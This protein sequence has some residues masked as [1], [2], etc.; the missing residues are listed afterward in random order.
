MMHCPDNLRFE[1]DLWNQGFGSIAGIDEV[2]RGPL[3]GPVVAA[4]VVFPPKF[5]LT[6]VTDSKKI[7]E[8]QR[9]ILSDLIKKH[10]LNIR[11]ATFVAMRDAINFLTTIPD[12]LLV[13]GEA[14]PDADLPQIGIVKGDARSFTIG[15]ASILAKV[16]RDRM[17]RTYHK[18]YPEYG[19]DRH[20][21]YGTSEHIARIKRY[22]ICPIHRS[23]FL[24]KILARIDNSHREYAAAE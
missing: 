14:L 8:D 21:G 24:R 9:E 15:A 1:T 17:M 20:K 5:H 7:K 18:K 16:T 22:G 4:A 6:K 13:D 12:Y 23:T 11:Q 3:A 10:V 2:G 19:F